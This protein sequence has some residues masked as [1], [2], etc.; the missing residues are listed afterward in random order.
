MYPTPS[1][2]LRPSPPRS[3]FVF[4]PYYLREGGRMSRDARARRRICP[5]STTNALSN[6]RGEQGACALFNAWAVLIES[7][8]LGEVVAVGRWSP[9]VAPPRI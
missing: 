5:I 9:T 6:V 4:L 3:S 8:S 1:P 2:R 7:I